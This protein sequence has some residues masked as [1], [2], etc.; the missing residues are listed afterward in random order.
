MNDEP[1]TQAD[2]TLH[3]LMTTA[4]GPGALTD[5]EIESLLNSSEPSLALSD[6]QS[7]RIVGKVNRL[8][9][10]AAKTSARGSGPV[11]P[12][13]Q[14]PRLVTATTNE[15][16]RPIRI[17]AVVALL[18]S[19]LAL[20]SVIMLMPETPSQSR[21]AAHLPESP[22]FSGRS[23]LRYW[24]TAKPLPDAVPA[25]KVAVGDEIATGDLERRRVTLPDGSVLYVNSGSQVKIATERRVEVTRGEVFVEVVPAIDRASH[26][27]QSSRHSLSD[28]AADPAT[29]AIVTQRV[30]ATLPFEVV[31]PNRTITALGTKFSVSVD[32]AETDVMVTQGKVKV[33]G[34][35]EV[36]AAG[37]QVKASGAYTFASAPQAS[38]ALEWTRDLMAAATGPLVPKSEFSGGAL[39][40]VDPNGQSSK[41]SLRNY[42]ID[43]HIEDGFARTTIDQT[44]FNHTHSRL[45]GTF[46]FPLP[47]DAS[48]SRLAMYVNGKLMEGGM[49]ERDHARNTFEEIKR[50]MLDPA[51]LEWVDGST[52]KMRV[53]PLEPRQEKRIVLSYSQRLNSAEGQLQY[54]FPAGHTMD[55]VRDWSAHVRI[56]GG[57]GS[58]WHSQSHTMTA[59]ED[60]GDLV[61]DAGLKNALMDRDLVLKV[62][63]NSNLKSQI[64]NFK[65]EGQ[66]YLMLRLRPDLPGE[67]QRQPHHWVFLFEH[68]GDRSP[69]LARAQIEIMRTLLENAEHSD[70]FSIVSAS[71]RAELYPAERQL[72]TAENTAAAIKHLENIH[73]VGA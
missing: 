42:H 62:A 4:I 63:D 51:L 36:V 7:Q 13:D 9:N 22:G 55:A 12:V 34:V 6:E 11:L 24:M 15:P 56:K 66:Q 58:E 39:V 53:F 59:T 48:L 69:L 54:R 70:T 3:R 25:A 16:S 26:G 29:L 47:T 40:T 17:P 8:L 35:D 45:E 28:E 27:T 44:Y 37:Q 31:T 64:S 50:K 1:Q 46:H 19:M 57:A 33:S 73:L 2:A 30:T 65:S 10:A 38:A 18:A 72:C 61:L 20:V 21:T 52:F 71:T 68:A 23:G 49:A 43:V 41:L 60:T 32:D 14:R 5:A 67:V